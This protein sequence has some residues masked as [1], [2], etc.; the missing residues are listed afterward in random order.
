M[1]FLGQI[2][3]IKVLILQ[4]DKLSMLMHV[5][6]H[7]LFQL[8]QGWG[9]I[10]ATSM[11]IANSKDLEASG[12]FRFLRGLYFLSADDFHDEDKGIT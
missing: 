11:Q 12:N 2:K 4:Q 3:R 7:N 6:S 8:R 10:N 5:L 1:D 9:Q